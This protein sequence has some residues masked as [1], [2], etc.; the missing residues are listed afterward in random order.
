MFIEAVSEAQKLLSATVPDHWDSDALKAREI[1]YFCDQSYPIFE[2]LEQKTRGGNCLFLPVIGYAPALDIIRFR[3]FMHPITFRW[4]N[5]QD[6]SSC[7]NGQPFG[8]NRHGPK[9]GGWKR[10]RLRSSSS[11]ALVISRTVRAT[12][13]DRA[14]SAAATSVWNSLPEADR[15]SASLAVFRKSLK[16]ALF[17]RSCSD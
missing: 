15:S 16:T 9:S 2:V 11:T 14:F 3:I 4:H 17:A 8:H 5:E 10:R 13:G 6:L 1:G 12:I 7:W